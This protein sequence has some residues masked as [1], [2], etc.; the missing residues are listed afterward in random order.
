MRTWVQSVIACVWY[1]GILLWT[2]TSNAAGQQS[3]GR[4]GDPFGDSSSSEAELESTD[5]FSSNETAFEIGQQKNPQAGSSQPSTAASTTSDPLGKNL[6]PLVFILRENPPQSPKDFGRALTWMTQL[7]HWTEVASLLDQIAARKWTLSQ[8][9]EI[10]R[11]AGETTWIRLRRESSQLSQAQQDLVDLLFQAPSN[12]A[13]NP[14]TIDQWIDQLSQ[15]DAS[16]RRLAQVRLQSGGSEA[17]ERLIQRLVA[18]GSKIPDLM[19]VGTIVE[20][21]QPGIEA[22]QTACTLS[23]STITTRFLLTIAD[24]PSNHF[25]I[26]LATGLQSVVYS[27]E[28]RNALAERLSK[29]GVRTPTPSATSTHLQKAFDSALEDYQDRRLDTGSLQDILWRVSEDGARVEHLQADQDIK[30]LERVYQLAQHRTV[31]STATPEDFHCLAALGFQ[32]AY[33]FDPTGKDLRLI[34]SV[35]EKLPAD[36]V[37]QSGFWTETFRQADR[38]QMHGGCVRAIELLTQKIKAGQVAP[39]MDFLS[40]LLID[41]RPII[42][43][44]T[45]QAIAS[46]DP[47]TAYAGAERALATCVEMLQLGQGATSLIIGANSELCMAAET[48]VGQSTQGSIKVVSSGR[49]ALQVLSEPYPADLI[50]IVDR[51]HD[52]SLFELLQRLRKTQGGGSLPIAVMTD[53]LYPHESQLVEDM[54]GVVSG[55]LSSDSE[56]VSRTVQQMLDSLDT[57]PISNEQRIAFQQ[58]ASEFLAK[59]SEDR[60]SY[61]FYPFDTWHESL[62]QLPSGSSSAARTQVLASLGTKLSQLKLVQMVVTSSATEQERLAAVR[63]FGNS[64][65]RFGTLLSTQDVQTAYDLYNRLGPNDPIIAKAMTKVLDILEA[66]AGAREWPTE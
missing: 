61:A 9:A 56:V 32:R 60:A 18:G 14:S 6:D 7:E 35:L 46:I 54:Q 28:I 3:D 59:I 5:E 15:P 65:R 51:V 39:P 49:Q 17:I 11:I 12:Y 48:A 23:D 31:L 40:E 21:G 38:W 25:P 1:L 4:D 8:Q 33:Q 2:P 13:R 43:Y 29:K 26:E 19:L 36:V 27:Q 30:S 62:I 41:S 34:Q 42:R 16:K 57:Q 55:V 45:L 22:L 53:R 66:Q 37:S 52:L 47:Q 64:I 50:V 58:V 44:L 63:A 10:S 24:L 20:F